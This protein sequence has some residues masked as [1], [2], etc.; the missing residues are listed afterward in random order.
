MT[1]DVA[2]KAEG[3]RRG[4]VG[5]WIFDRGYIPRP[6]RVVR[7]MRRML[8]WVAARG[9]THKWLNREESGRPMT[10]AQFTARWK[11]WQMPTPRVVEKQ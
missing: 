4:S 9:L 7:F 3:L 1:R 6:S 10:W 2:G 8:P 5:H 11:Q